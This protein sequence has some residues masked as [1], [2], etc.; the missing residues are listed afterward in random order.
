MSRSE[1]SD[2]NHIDLYM[3]ILSWQLSKKLQ[4]PTQDV[5]EFRPHRWWNWLAKAVECIEESKTGSELYINGLEICITPQQDTG[6]YQHAKV[7]SKGPEVHLHCKERKNI[8]P[9]YHWRG[10]WPKPST[11]PLT[12]FKNGIIVELGKAKALECIPL[13]QAS[14]ISSSSNCSYQKDDLCVKW[15][16]SIHTRSSQCALRGCSVCKYV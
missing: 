15:P 10:D 12:N 6:T 13:M 4:C 2:F 11:R 1:S 5:A 7:R 14:I 9:A 16:T 3:L 8:Q